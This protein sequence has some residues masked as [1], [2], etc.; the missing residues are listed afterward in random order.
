MARVKAPHV[1]AHGGDAGFL[2]DL[3]KV[4]GVF[5]AVGDWDFHQHML[6]RAHHLL[7]LAEMHLRG[8]GQ[9]HRVRALDAL[10]QIA[11]EMR[12]TVFLGDLRG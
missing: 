7:A 12:N 11:G 5:D 3:H 1:A 9:D 10:R 8:R 2:G 6:A 4:L